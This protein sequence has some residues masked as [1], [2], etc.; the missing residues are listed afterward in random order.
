MVAEWLAYYRI[1]EKLGA[2]ARGEVYLAEDTRLGRTAALKLLSPELAENAMRLQR[3][4]REAASA[5][6]HPN[7]AHIYEI[8][9]AGGLHFIA[10]ERVEG[11]PLSA[12]L[13]TGS[14]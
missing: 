10:M 13:R 12:R 6:N 7:V 14:V 5:I 8:G 2:G 4:I 11:Q 1:S 9:K 3:F